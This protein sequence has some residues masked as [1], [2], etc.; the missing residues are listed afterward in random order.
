M[1]PPWRK[2]SRMKLQRQPSPD[3]P[4]PLRI[5]KRQ[6]SA[7]PATG[8]RMSNSQTERSGP[9][10]GAD[11]HL[12]VM[13]R[14]SAG[15]RLIGP[16]PQVG[17]DAFDSI[18]ETWTSSLSR[19]HGLGDVSPRSQGVAGAQTLNVKKTRQGRSF[20]NGR[21]GLGIQ[22]YRN[23][24]MSGKGKAPTR[25]LFTASNNLLAAPSTDWPETGSSPTPAQYS[26]RQIPGKSC[27]LCPDIT[28][29]AEFTALD[30]E[31]RSVWAA[32]EV[33]GRLAE[34]LEKPCADVSGIAAGSFINRPLG[35]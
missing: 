23:R 17:F 14:R 1:V 24:S 12:T 31:Q 18:P 3:A 21:E 33:S 9:V 2:S 25:E 8:D 6:G 29:T 13:K 19:R 16:R 22:T 10:A 20:V 15:G 27:V 32:I 34:I 26:G 30:S 11:E 28:V 5:V 7:D 4:S 35:L